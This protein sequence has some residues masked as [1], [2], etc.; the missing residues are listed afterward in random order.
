MKWL[1]LSVVLLG[2]VSSG[3]AVES[4]LDV[5][6]NGSKL[7]QAKFV[8]SEDGKNFTSNA[9]LKVAGM[10]FL[11]DLSCTWDGKQVAALKFIADSPQAKISLERKGDAYSVT[12]GGR[13]TEIKPKNGFGSIIANLHPQTW[14]F[15]IAELLSQKSEKIDHKSFL[16]DSAIDF[17][18]TISK[19]PARTL[20]TQQ[21]K[22]D[23]LMF[24]IKAGPM[25][26]SVA[27]D[28]ANGTVVGFD[29]PSQKLQM[30]VPGLE[31]LF[32]DPMKKFPELSQLTYASEV[33]SQVASPMRD[34]TNLIADIARP[35][36]VGKYPTILVRTPYG[37]ASAFLQESAEDWAKRG[38]VMV[39]QD[40]RGRGDSQGNWDP[41][42]SERQ[43]GYDTIDWITKQPWSDGKVGMIGGSYL[44]SVQ[45]QAA[46]EGHPALKCIVPQVAPPDPMHNIP[47]DE[48]VPALFGNLW[49]L[50]LT[51]NAK[52][53]EMSDTSVGIIG[54]SGFL[55]IPL[56]AVD[57]AVFKM[58]LPHWD[59]WLKRDRSTAWNGWNY[60]SD[61]RKAN[62]PALMISG[63]WDGDGIGTK[64]NWTLRQKLGLESKT[65]MIYGPWPHG[66]NASTTYADQDYGP[67]ALLDLN[68]V[69]LR[70][71]DTWLKGK[72]A[73]LEN[74]PRVK[75]FVTGKNMWEGA[76]S[77]PDLRTKKKTLFLAAPNG[78][79]YPKAGELIEKPLTKVGLSKYLYDPAKVT[80]PS[81]IKNIAEASTIFDPKDYSGDELFFQSAPQTTDTI[82]S[83]PI[84]ARLFVSTTAKDADFFI[85]IL[86]VDPKGVKR[87][88]GLPG[89][90]RLS[91]YG[92][93]HDPKAITPNKVYEVEIKHWDTAHQFKK[94]H[95]VGLLVTSNFF[96]VFA[97]NFGL[98]EPPIKATKMVPAWQSVYHGAKRASALTYYSR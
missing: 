37:R 25:I 74:E 95:R 29:V 76:Q 91:Y 66:F 18:V 75:Y 52:S 14:Q 50:N 30:I 72:P 88:I 24:D 20:E 46:V 10:K 70:W 3:Y 62:I 15:A 89:K 8:G 87:I 11:S 63:W 55:K 5:Y 48:G 51:R 90:V 78:A 61:M 7:G 32:E 21:G 43:D 2:L 35:K 93:V 41:F 17:S 22:K 4:T 47:Y 82:I 73:K 84:S 96:P 45:W 71:F 36:P 83:G 33:L 67:T 69:Y 79:V 16:L 53:V 1:G 6:I 23:V 28:A 58:D 65:W 97:R 19:K 68:T 39:V 49:W 54:N 40:V 12:V 13:T 64:L 85:S 56:S 9:D 38:Y 57:N 59:S 86:D 44:G 94:G 26:G 92:R 31:K 81:S 77:W 34:G 80:I 27:Y 60:Q 42:M 98:A